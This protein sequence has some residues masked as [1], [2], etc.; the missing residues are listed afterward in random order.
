M[1]E[2]ENSEDDAIPST[3]FHVDQRVYCP[4]GQNLYEAIIRKTKFKGHMWTY[5]VHFLG[6]NTRW[7]RWVQ[8]SLLQE[9]TE[10]LRL[11]AVA[12][13]V[14]AKKLKQAKVQEKE[15]KKRK[16]RE[17]DGD[18]RS[19]RRYDGGPSWEDYCELP[20]T[21]KTV[22]VDEKE[23]IMRISYNGP[24]AGVDTNFSP[25]HWKPLHDVHS[26]PSSVTIKTVLNHYIKVKKKEVDTPEAVEAAEKKARTF[27]NGL[28]KL[29]EDALP[30]CLL[31][32]PERAQYLT[33]RD[34]PSTKGKRATE[35]YSCEFLLRLFVRLPVLLEQTPS[36]AASRKEMGQQLQELIVL[37][38][39]NRQSCFKA[40]YREPKLEELNDFEKALMSGADQTTNGSTAAISMD[41]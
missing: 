28:A 29:F 36:D 13:E 15:E 3:K 19:K 35:I 11:Q 10:E 41:T 26:L 37:L 7:D 14:K 18:G 2:E 40:K 4:E 17:L 5:F 1:I 24:K 9:P 25:G 20:F 16:K 30:V 21:L 8:E 39:K 34:D 6:W 32:H 38:Q 27:V 12:Q 33:L 23:R 22:L 31:Y